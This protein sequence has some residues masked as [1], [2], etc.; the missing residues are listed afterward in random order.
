MRMSAAP[1]LA[2]VASAAV[3]VAACSNVDRVSSPDAVRSA[4]PQ[5]PA[6]DIGISAAAT[7]QV[8]VDPSSPAASYTFT[9]T[10]PTNLQTGDAVS[11][12][13]TINT[14]V[15]GPNCA[16]VLLRTPAGSNSEI[17]SVTITASTGAA[18]TFSFVCA[19][20]GGPT[21][22][23]LSGSNGAG[24]GEN[25]FHGSTVTF[26][27]VPTSLTPLF[28]IGDDEAN[29][30]GADV[31]F[32]GAQWWKNNFMTGSVSKGVAAFKGYATSAD[33]FCGGTWTSLPGNS[34]VP[35]ATIGSQIAIIVTSTVG[36]VGPAISGD[37]VKILLVNTD[38]GYG[39]NPGHAGTGVVAS[40]V[41]TDE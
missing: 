36:K 14:S 37:I 12:P 1:R 20:D 21:C 3:I 5:A 19:T 40:V 24:A 22:G 33:D 26:T 7:V 27:F 39:P 11:T 31:N 35:P 30:I 32:W 28:V 10:S 29:G 38:A 9:Q 6:A 4:A 41:C 15:P 23:S 18:G 8:C 25:S 17:A 13:V 2:L 34:S 16:D